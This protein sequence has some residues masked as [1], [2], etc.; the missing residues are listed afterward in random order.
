MDTSFDIVYRNDRFKKT[1]VQFHKVYTANC[2]LNIVKSQRF[3]KECLRNFM[4]LPTLFPM[5]EHLY[6]F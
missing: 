1:F 3:V 4:I 5:D 6:V 2:M